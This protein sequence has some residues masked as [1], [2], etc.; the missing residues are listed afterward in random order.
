MKILSEVES[1]TE[2][3][4]PLFLA[5]DNSPSVEE[6]TL[7]K[8][9]SDM[10]RKGENFFKTIFFLD[11]PYRVDDVSP[12]WPS[13]EDKK[14]FEDSVFQVFSEA[15][16]KI[17]SID[18]SC[19]KVSKGMRAY[20]YLHPKEFSGEVRKGVIPE[21]EGLIEQIQIV[22]LRAIKL[23]RNTYPFCTES[24]LMRF[25]RENRDL[26]YWWIILQFENGVPAG[27]VNTTI[28][29][30][31]KKI[32]FFDHGTCLLHQQFI[33]EQC[34]LDLFYTLVD[35]GDIKLYKNGKR[36]FYKAKSSKWKLVKDRS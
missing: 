11:S 10:F 22:K 28:G 15:G 2:K 34:M 12:G 5:L 36:P 6:M 13:A 20:L 3:G 26:F 1:K 25:I 14:A 7:A 30:M 27:M 16:W 19:I 33:A 8:S 24:Q 18:N 29:E 4:T 31:L 35:V 17:E 21:V 32:R 23:F 9:Y